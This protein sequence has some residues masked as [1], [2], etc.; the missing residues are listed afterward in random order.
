MGESMR[1]RDKEIRD[2]DEIDRIISD[3]PVCRLGLVDEGGAYIVPM[4]FAYD[5]TGSGTLY[6]HSAK[7][8]R[9]IRCIGA[10]DRASFEIDRVFELTSRRPE[11]ACTWSMSYE[12]VMGHG[13]IVLVDNA[14]EKRSALDRIM[15][16]YAGRDGWDYPD[17]MV[18]RVSII[19]LEIEELHGKRSPA[20][21]GDTD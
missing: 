7:E 13:R 8:G 19:S 20:V 5:A 12:S 21:H 14:D 9:K 11:E 18:E 2:R 17:A 1:R 6:F 16:R 3:A 4:S 15:A 10:N